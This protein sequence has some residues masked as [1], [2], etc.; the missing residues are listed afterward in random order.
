LGLRGYYLLLSPT[1]TD[2]IAI[3]YKTID[4]ACYTDFEFNSFTYNGVSQVLTAENET[5]VVK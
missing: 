2:T 3:N 5:I 4:E 1:E